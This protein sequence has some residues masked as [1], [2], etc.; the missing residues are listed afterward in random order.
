MLIGFDLYF[1]NSGFHYESHCELGS[2]DVNEVPLQKVE[3]Q[4]A[5]TPLQLKYVEVVT[6]CF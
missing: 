5:L 2:V 1:S 6:E 4:G 3:R